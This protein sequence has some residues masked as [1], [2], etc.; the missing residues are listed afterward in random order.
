M[1][2][3]SE[4]ADTIQFAL[5]FVAAEDDH[6]AR[7]EV[8]QYTRDERLAK[9]TGT[10]GDEDRRILEKAHEYSY[11]VNETDGSGH[12]TAQLPLAKLTI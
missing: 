9:G 7:I 11:V 5:E 10:T 6:A 3:C 4:R 12:A 1:Y 2:S 8:V